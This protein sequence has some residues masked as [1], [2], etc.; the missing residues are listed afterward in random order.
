MDQLKEQKRCEVTARATPKLNKCPSPPPAENKAP[1][2]SPVATKHQF[3]PKAKPEIVIKLPAAPQQQPPDEKLSSPKAKPSEKKKDSVFDIFGVDEPPKQDKTVPPKLCISVPSLHSLYDDEDEEDFMPTNA[4][5]IG[6]NQ[7]KPTKVNQ[8]LREKKEP[9]PE[10]AKSTP[11]PVAAPPPQ[12]IATPPPVERIEEHKLPPPPLPSPKF[13][14]A[15]QPLD[16]LKSLDPEST[17]VDDFLQQIQ[18]QRQRIEEKLSSSPKKAPKFSLGII[19]IDSVQKEI[20]DKLEQMPDDFP[21]LPL[22]GTTENNLDKASVAESST[23]TEASSSESSSESDSDTE[24]SES[25]SSS[26][27]SSSSSD[28]SVTDDDDSAASTSSEDNEE[29]NSL[30]G[31]KMTVGHLGIDLTLA[32]RSP[33]MLKIQQKP[34]VIPILKVLAEEEEPGIDRPKMDIKEAISSKSRKETQRHE[35]NDRRERTS[36]DRRGK[37]DRLDYG[38]ESSRKHS[39]RHERSSRREP[40]LRDRD[41][42]PAGSRKKDR[43]RS[44]SRERKSW[45]SRSTSH[46][47]SPISNRARMPDIR[48]H[49]SRS[50]SRSRSLSLDRGEGHGRKRSPWRP[51]IDF[52]ENLNVPTTSWAYNDEQYFSRAYYDESYN[53]F[54]QNQVNQHCNAYPNANHEWPHQELANGGGSTSPMRGSLDDRINNVLNGGP[55]AA[56]HH[57]QHLQ[58]Q[59]GGGSY[60]PCYDGPSGY[61]DYN[62]SESNY[63]QNNNNQYENRSGSD[64]YRQTANLLSISCNEGYP[65]NNNN[66]PRRAP[67]QGHSHVNHVSYAV[68]PTPP[69]N[70]SS[71]PFALQKGNVIELVPSVMDQNH[72]SSGY[73]SEENSRGERRTAASKS[74]QRKAI[75]EKKRMEKNMRKKKLEM[76]LQSLLDGSPGIEDM[77]I[78]GDK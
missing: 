34:R 71:S 17:E 55:A 77:I 76:E 54:E 25:S 57:P 59:G 18:E 29:N 33:V 23:G 13:S 67:Q 28:S 42:H 6:S 24:S 58:Q 74:A 11:T 5:R 38:R 56:A 16:I 46:S 44:K 2:E 49:D 9:K 75:R 41:S 40:D 47:P 39:S 69:L 63:Y 21:D 26:S 4:L 7:I 27:E 43:H 8:L 53:Y 36:S 12:P 66:T 10:P 61:A 68:E 60:A 15:L 22:P 70:F 50:R 48:N 78:E 3:T 65:T 62:R 19:D 64:Q 30:P 52:W 20:N 32:S 51:P 45:R 1:V 31:T 35:K 37:R 14:E 72:S 73:Q